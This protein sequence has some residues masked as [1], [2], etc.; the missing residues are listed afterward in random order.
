LHNLEW[1]SFRSLRHKVICDLFGSSVHLR[2]FTCGS[3]PHELRSIDLAI[4]AFISLC[5]ALVSFS[6]FCWNSELLEFLGMDIKC[7]VGNFDDRLILD[8]GCWFSNCIFYFKNHVITVSSLQMNNFRVWFPI[9]IGIID[10]GIFNFL[11]S[12]K[13]LVDFFST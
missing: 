2:D 10:I 8:I 6:S 11:D 3:I 5:F 4:F 12:V 7:P 13:S 9:E 1:R